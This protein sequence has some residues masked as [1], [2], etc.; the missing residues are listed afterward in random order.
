MQVGYWVDDPFVFST[1]MIQDMWAVSESVL[2]VLS[3][4]SRSSRVVGTGA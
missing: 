2:S 4:K 3:T 1:P